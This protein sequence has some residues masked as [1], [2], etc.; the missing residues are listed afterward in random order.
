MTS[1]ATI[2]RSDS[3]L[4][5]TQS[6]IRT[7]ALFLQ[8]ETT[9]KSCSLPQSQ[10]T[11]LSLTQV[12]SKKKFLSSLA[13]STKPLIKAA[14]LKLSRM[15]S[16]SYLK[17]CDKK[18]PRKT[19]LGNYG[20]PPVSHLSSTLNRLQR[21]IKNEMKFIK[22]KDWDE[23]LEEANSN[24]DYLHK[25]IKRKKNNQITYPP[26]LGYRGLVYGTLEKA[27]LFADTLEESFKEYTDPYDD[28]PRCLLDGYFPEAWKHAIITLL[29]KNGK[30]KKFAINYRPISL[31]S[32]IGKIFEKILLKRIN[33]HADAN[34][35]IPDFQHGFREETATNHQ[36]LR[37]TNLVIGGFNQHETT[38]G[39]F[40]D[41]EKAFDR[42]WHDGLIFKLIK[43]NFP[44]YIIKA[45]NSYLR[46]RSFQVKITSTLSRTASISAGCPQGIRMQKLKLFGNSI[47]WAT[48][49][50]YLGVTLDSKLTSCPCHDEFRGPRSDYVRQPI[51]TYACQIWGSAAPSNIS[52]L[53]IEQNKALRIITSYPRHLH[54]E[55]AH[56]LC[57]GASTKEYVPSPLSQENKVILYKRILRPVITYGSPVWGAAAATHMKKIQVI[58]NKILRVMTNA[59]WYVRNDV[60]HNDLHMEPIS[61]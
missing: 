22:K 30:D 12:T 1:P 19:G 13:T 17:L 46:D 20:R 52:K 25:I 37:L 34:N 33:Q 40:L 35:S 44:L 11:L 8:I 2:T 18:S 50:E 56:G 57:A 41:A 59:P 38:G 48:K 42:V 23:T 32:A 31:L 14:N 7:T 47:P 53:Q 15:T 9:I 54:E 28:E 21:Q 49:V 29:P 3:S 26:L 27:N 16:L 5:P 55:K 24:I 61:N 43:L 39:A 4:K 36:L 58:Q 51:L 10:E 45:I 60:I 6:H